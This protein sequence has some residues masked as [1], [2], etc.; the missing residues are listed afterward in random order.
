M[1]IRFTEGFYQDNKD[2]ISEIVSKFG[3]SVWIETWRFCFFYFTLKSEFNF[4]DNLGKASAL[5]K[6]SLILRM[7]N[8]MV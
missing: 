6:I 3:K 2:F 1:A 7:E 8:D 4:V 5:S